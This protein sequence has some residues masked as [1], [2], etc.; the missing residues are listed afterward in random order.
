[1]KI[2]NIKIS[3]KLIALLVAGGITLAPIP[4]TCVTNNS[5]DPG[6]FVKSVEEIE[7]AKYGIYIVKEGDNLS[8]ISEKV[9]SHERIDITTKYWIVLAALNDYPR[10][11]HENDEIIFPLD[12][13]EL[14][15]LYVSLSKSGWKAKYI[16]NNKIYAERKKVEISQKMVYDLLYDIYGDKVCIDPDFVKLFFDYKGLSDKYTITPSDYVPGKALYD[17]TESIPTLEELEEYRITNKP[18]VKVK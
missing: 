13:D 9:C 11:I 4:G 3:R 15:D 1:M 16:Q 14:E 10:V 17:M 6:T 12:P 5:Y 18:K 8:R 7:D 2:E